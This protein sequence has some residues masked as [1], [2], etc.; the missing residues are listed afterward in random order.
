MSLCGEADA[1]VC[2]RC[3]AEGCGAGVPGE[4]VVCVVAPGPGLVAAA[5][6]VAHRVVAVLLLRQAQAFEVVVWCGL[7]EAAELVVAVLGS[8]QVAVDLGDVVGQVVLVGFEGEQLAGV[9]VG[10][11]VFD[12]DA[13]VALQ[14]V[15]GQG[16]GGAGGGDLSGGVPL[17]VAVADLALV[18]QGDLSQ[19]AFV[20]GVALWAAVG[21]DV[22]AELAVGVKALAY[23]EGEGSAAGDL[24]IGDGALRGAALRVFGVAGAADELACAVLLFVAGQQTVVVVLAADAL[25]QGTALQA[26]FFQGHAPGGVVGVGAGVGAC[27]RSFGQLVCCVIAVL[28]GAAQGSG[29][30]DEAPCLVVVKAVG[31]AVGVGDG[32]EVVLCVPALL[33]ALVETVDGLYQAA[34][35]VVAVLSGVACGVGDLKGLMFCTAI[36][37]QNSPQPQNGQTNGEIKIP[38]PVAPSNMQGLRLKKPY[39]YRLQN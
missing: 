25:V 35:G 8:A 36:E 14:G 38:N 29:F 13:G 16:F 17:V 9:V 37:H 30:F 28:N 15:V 3:T 5:G 19:A 24:A 39:P 33:G 26:V 21:V 22:A 2:G 23:R 27:I 18:G 31:V 1:G 32:G 4:L 10:V 6:A 12:F 11:V 7:G 34:Q 20:V